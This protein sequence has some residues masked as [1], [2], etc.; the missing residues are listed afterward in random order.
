M[1]LELKDQT[2]PPG[3]APEIKE[4]FEGFIGTWKTF[5]EKVETEIKELKAGKKDAVTQDE[6]KKLND[7]LDQQQKTIEKLQLR[8][9]RTPL[10]NG[11]N[12]EAPEAVEYKRG[13]DRFMRKGQEDGLRDLEQKAVSAGTDP[14]GGYVVPETIDRDILR[15]QTELSD[16][17]QIASL[18]QIGGPSF[19][20][21]I[22]LGGSGY[23]WVGEKDTRPET[24]TPA[25]ARLEFPVHELY[26]MPAATQTLLDD[27]YISV[28]SW[29]A[30]EVAIRFAEVEGDAFINGNGSNKPRGFLAGGYSKVANANWAWGK[31]GFI[32]TGA[33]G[34]FKTASVG[35]D[36]DNLVDMV[37]SLKPT[38]RAGAVWVMNRNTQAQVRK[39]KNGDGTPYW[40]PN[41]TQGQPATVMGYP[42]REMPDMPDI[43]DNAYAIAFGNFQRGY[44]IVER[45]GTRVL[46]DP[47]S[48][49]PYVLYY[50]TKRVGGGIH[51]FDAIKLLQFAD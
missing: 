31:V 51:D 33:A 20:K 22:N 34:A 3:M 37:Y 19:I 40:Q 30:E 10:D 44:V 49:K 41:F 13:F 38:Y 45:M 47:F 39:M 8:Q 15:I 17:R 46:R 21:P 29:L 18:R 35:D 42:V 43:A 4:A 24:S 14:D 28:E 9:E 16:V 23:G 12:H 48:S 6:I 27:A 7:S 25:L 32:K 36:H 11:D 26:A 2:P 5:Q 1:R 50:T